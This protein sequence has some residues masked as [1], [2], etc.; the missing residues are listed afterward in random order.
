MA[1]LV[2][3]ASSVVAGAGAVNAAGIAGEAIAAGKAVYVSSTTRKIMLADSNAGTAEA[4]RAIGIAL[5]GAALDQPVGYIKSGPLT[6][7]AVLT[8][9]TPF[10]LSDTPGGICPIADVGTGE[11][12]CQLGIASSTTVLQVNIQNTGVAN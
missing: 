7:N 8:A 9:N 1:D 12:L 6:M 5:N 3:T 11:Y 4:R 2:I 10:F